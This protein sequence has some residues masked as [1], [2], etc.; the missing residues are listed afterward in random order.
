MKH[1]DLYGTHRET[2]DD[3]TLENLAAKNS[4]EAFEIAEKAF[5]AF[6]FF[7]CKPRQE[8]DGSTVN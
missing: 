6:Y 2:G 8:S 1:Y 5:P 7:M 4:E 3:V